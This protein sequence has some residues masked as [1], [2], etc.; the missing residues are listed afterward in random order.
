MLLARLASILAMLLACGPTLV[1]AAPA[2]CR[3]EFLGG[4]PPSLLN[5]KLARDSYPLCSNGFATLFSGLT[6]TPV[7][8]AEHLTADRI[9]AARSMVRVNSFHAEGRLPDGVRSELE[10]YRGSGYDR[11]HMAPNGDMGDAGS[12]ADSFS[13][14]NMIPQDHANN[15]GIWAAIEE[16][17]RDTA[18]ADGEAYV[19]TGPLYQGSDLQVI[20]G[21]VFVPT[22]IWKAI[23]NPVSGEAGAYLAD[24]APGRA[25]RTL[26][27]AELATLTGID[28]FPALPE[29]V[30]IA[31]PDLPTIGR[32]GRA[33][34]GGN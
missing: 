17:A 18:V 10:D 24:N 6:R 31:A 20:N 14:A 28:A 27:I 34:D 16:A 25:Y 4:T 1:L 8:S 19:V 23:Y 29:G 26:S 12:Q 5:T 33:R 30:K 2:A 22:G 9:G 3:S 21:R 15:A 11:G 13:L 7:Y 32:Q